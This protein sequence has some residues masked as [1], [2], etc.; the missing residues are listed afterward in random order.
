MH[1]WCNAWCF[2]IKYTKP[3]PKFCK[4]LFDFENSQIFQQTLKVRSQKMKCMKKWMRKSLIREKNWSWD[5]RT[6]GKEIWSEWERF[7]RWK[8]TKQSREIEEMRSEIARTLYIESLKSR[9]IKRC[10][11]VSRFINLDKCIYRVAI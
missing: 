3:I 9:Q 1:M 11:E 5:Q 2:K 10:R 8:D 6:L 4:N 7:R